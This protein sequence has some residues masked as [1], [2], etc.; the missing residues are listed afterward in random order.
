MI[1]YSLYWKC[2]NGNYITS[3]V[4]DIYMFIDPWIND[5]YISSNNCSPINKRDMLWNLKFEEFTF[6]LTKSFSIYQLN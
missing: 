3:S 2:G 5:E 1:K 4:C 6:H